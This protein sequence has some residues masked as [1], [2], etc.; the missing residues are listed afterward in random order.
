MLHSVKVDE[1]ISRAMAQAEAEEAAEDE[2]SYRTSVSV[3]SESISGT[4]TS[5]SAPG[6][7]GSRPTSQSINDAGDENTKTRVSG[8]LCCTYMC[9]C[10]FCL[11]HGLLHKY[12]YK[13]LLF[14][15]LDYLLCHACYTATI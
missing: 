8:A 15:K 9:V 11:L 1:Y 6:G 2:V 12:F 7:S 5:T 10:G 14:V 4:N 3:H 13:F